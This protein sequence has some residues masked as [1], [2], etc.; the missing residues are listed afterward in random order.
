V[1]VVPRNLLGDARLDVNVS[2]IAEVIHVLDFAS[3][4]Q[5]DVRFAGHGANMRGKAYL[6]PQLSWRTDVLTRV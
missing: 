5:L 2:L 3:V 1:V 4:V 6:R